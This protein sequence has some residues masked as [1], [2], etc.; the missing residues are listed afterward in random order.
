MKWMFLPLKRYVDFDGRSSRSEFW[1]FLL[2][3]L[4]VV[5]GLTAIGIGLGAYYYGRSDPTPLLGLPLVAAMIFLL[6]ILV[7]LIAVMV[8]RLHDRDLS[9]WFVL[10][11]LIPY[12]GW[13]ISIVFMMLPGTPG[14]NTHGEN[15][16]EEQ[17][18][19]PDQ[20]EQ[21]FN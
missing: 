19:Q 20:L 21:I 15:P 13:L 2:F 17:A 16:L 9:G 11:N 3:V 10:I 6:A 14:P 4:T 12:V 18:H 5:I 7:P 1:W 8:R